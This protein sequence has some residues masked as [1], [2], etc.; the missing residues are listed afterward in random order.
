MSLKVFKVNR[1]AGR[2]R[3]W[4]GGPYGGDQVC[5]S[6]TRAARGAEQWEV[7]ARAERGKRWYSR[8]IPRDFKFRGALGAPKFESARNRSE[9]SG[10]RE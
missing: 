1:G 4:V 7:R 2:R 8:A 5:V 9:M 6:P 10:W 3:C